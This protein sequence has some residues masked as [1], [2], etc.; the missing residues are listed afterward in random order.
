MTP[1]VQQTGFARAMVAT[2]ETAAAEPSAA[3]DGRMVIEIGKHRLIIVD[4]GVDGAAPA[5]ELAV[6]ERR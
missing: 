6:V 3:P 1:E 5:R 2:A 4:A